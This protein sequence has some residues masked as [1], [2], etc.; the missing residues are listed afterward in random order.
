MFGAVLFGSSFG[1]VLAV[2]LT[3]VALVLLIVALLLVFKGKPIEPA[4]FRF[5]EVP[6]AKLVWPFPLFFVL[7]FLWDIDLV[8]WALMLVAMFVVVLGATKSAWPARR[9]VP[10]PPLEA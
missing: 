6:M 2:L 5:E 1:P 4:Q 10:P 7:G 9:N 3:P 8:P